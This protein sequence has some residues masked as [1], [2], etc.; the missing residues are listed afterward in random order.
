MSAETI[1]VIISAA[2]L[3]LSFFGAFGWLIHRMDAR[4]D[5]VDERF[6][7]IDQRFDRVSEQFDRVGERIDQLQREVVEVKIGLARIE[8]P[9]RRIVPAR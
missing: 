8:G 6:H 1:A 5:R 9:E 3:L 2:S 7:R 4:F